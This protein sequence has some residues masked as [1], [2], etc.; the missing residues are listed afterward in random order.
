[1]KLA[2]ELIELVLE[3]IPL[4]KVINLMGLECSDIVF[5]WLFASQDHNF[6]I[7]EL[8]KNRNEVPLLPFLV[9]EAVERGDVPIVKW[10]LDNYPD[11]D[12]NAAI[13]DAVRLGH[14]E[15]LTMLNRHTPFWAH[16][17]HA[18]AAASLG[19][20][21]IVK[22]Y[23]GNI[24]KRPN[25]G[26]ETMD[27][28]AGNGHL[29]IV[30]WL[31]E[32]DD[33]GCTHDAMD[34]A[35]SNGFL[36][37]VEWLHNNRHEGSSQSGMDKAAENGHFGIVKFLHENRTEGCTPAA[38]DG[39]AGNGHLDIVKYLHTN[40]TE[41]CTRMAMDRAACN[42]HLEVV[43]WLRENRNEGYYPQTLSGVV[44]NGHTRVL[45]WFLKNTKCRVSK[46]ALILARMRG[47]E[48]IVN[49]WEQS[50]KKIPIARN[51]RS[52]RSLNA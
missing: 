21:H 32:N 14:L 39:A 27:A 36:N 45:K 25:S 29:D 17:Y 33:D 2:W 40:R 9:M 13:T 3:Y 38:M 19:Y 7:L 6:R 47:F 48:E 8:L 16:D 35:A 41:G 5:G 37:V 50:Q 18:Q 15:I 31:H 51:K 10:I 30:E 44:I 42:G 26:M 11:F 46:D 52:R 23:Y 49:L 34:L 1:M 4:L 28:A 20:F 22:W 24:P 12:S 43:E